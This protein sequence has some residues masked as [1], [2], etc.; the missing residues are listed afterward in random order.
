MTEMASHKA[1]KQLHSHLGIKF[2]YRQGI[3]LSGVGS[4]LQSRGKFQG[5]NSTG[6][7]NYSCLRNRSS[8]NWKTNRFY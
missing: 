7:S 3:C 6:V 5:N 8:V 2:G 4:V 1:T